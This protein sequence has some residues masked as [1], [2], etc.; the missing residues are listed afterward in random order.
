MIGMR[1]TGGC[2]PGCCDQGAFKSDPRRMF[3]VR[4]MISSQWCS[5]S[6]KAATSGVVIRGARFPYNTERIAEVEKRRIESK[7]SWVVKGG[8]LPKVWKYRNGQL[9]SG[10]VSMSYISCEA[11]AC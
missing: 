7:K 6:K 4:T 8:L 1:S 2:A 5:A 10:R 3:V 11:S 9:T